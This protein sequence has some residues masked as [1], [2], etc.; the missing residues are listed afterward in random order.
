MLRR[1][2]L[3]VGYTGPCFFGLILWWL[4]PIRTALKFGSDEG[5]ELM[6]ASLVNEGYPLYSTIWNDQ[7]PLHTELLALIFRIFG[8]TVYVGRL[9]ALGFSTLLL[10]AMYR[11]VSVRS[12][13]PAGLLAI[14]FLASSPYFIRL[15]V[16][17]ML[18]I[19][20]FALTMVALWSWTE[21]RLRKSTPWLSFTGVFLAC[22][23]QTK[24]T[25]GIF[26]PAWCLEFIF[27]KNEWKR[28][29]N[30]NC[31]WDYVSAIQKVAFPFLITFALI[32][33]AFY[34]RST[35]AVF[36]D[37][38]FSTG[39]H[40]Q[41]ASIRELGLTYLQLFNN[42]GL[43]F[44]SI[45]GILISAFKQIHAS[46]LPLLMLLTVLVV[47]L[48]H[49]P[50]WY[51]Y[52]LHFAIP[53]AWLAAIGIVESF[54]LLL[55]IKTRHFCIPKLI[56]WIAW[57]SVLTLLCGLILQNVF[58]ETI[59]LMKEPSAHEN[60]SVAN[61]KVNKAITHWAA[62]DRV[63]YPFWAGL[64]VPPE[65]A[66]IP[67]KRIWSKQINEQA[68]LE[69]FIRYHPEQVLLTSDWKYMPA[70]RAYLL[71]NYNRQP[72]ESNELFLKKHFPNSLDGK[73]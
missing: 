22:A 18:E 53:L 43:I 8:P 32:S 38:H 12:G 9:M 3:A 46:I 47:H 20:A 1:C 44:L 45:I 5:Y 24:L 50:Y 64:L 10:V 41:S 55:D 70:L 73:D 13:R 28:Q 19:P 52:Y 35:P 49:S 48:N 71:K 40:E 25:A 62:A 7:P 6:K 21:F 37:S 60:E 69:C 63:I 2:L 58:D 42:P 26:I 4:L 11:I 54:R 68:I 39:T 57:S 67:Q 65:L 27:T 17:V 33:I 61:L 16:S 56:Q 51:Y 59:S 23:L 34:D 72:L 29:S 15:S 14:G 36:W 31:I 66:V 30:R